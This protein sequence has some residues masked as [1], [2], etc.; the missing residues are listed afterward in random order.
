MNRNPNYHLAVQDFQSA[1]LRGKLQGV[2]AR[3]TGKSNELLSYEE[4]A[5]KLKLQGRSDKGVQMIPVDAIIGSVGRY[6]DFTRTFLPR[7]SGDQQ[8]WANVKTV[9]MNPVSEGLK[10]IE[11]YKVSDVYFV[12]DGNHRVSIA[13]QDGWKSIE[14]HVIEIQTDIPLTPDVQ[15]EELIVKAEYADFLEQTGMNKSQEPIDLKITIPGG[16]Q[17][18]LDEISARRR[19]M[20]EE[21]HKEHPPRD[22]AESWYSEIYMPFAEAVRER[23]MMRWFPDRTI[24]DLYVWMSEHRGELEKELGWTIRP[25]AAAEAVIQTRSRRATAE[26]SK[27]GSW[28]KARLLNRYSEHLFRDILVPIGRSPESWD[29]LEQAIQIAHRE[30]AN[31]LALHTVEKAQELEKP[32][33]NAL[34]DQFNK[35]CEEKAA[36]GVLAVEVGEPTQKI[37]E[38]AALADLIVMK[39]MYPPSTGIK[40]LTSQVRTLITR[41]S[42]PILAIPGR[43]SN[44][45]HALLAFD[46]SAK[47]KEALF[48]ATYLAEQWQT[49]L[50]V[51]TGLPEQELDTSAQDFARNYLEFNEVEASFI[52]QKYSPAV[53]KLTAEEINADL[54]I[55]GGY[56][57]SILKEM[58][59]GSSVNEMLRGF[60]RPVL[61]CR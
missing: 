29:A 13:R 55:M 17:K 60:L 28:R 21:Q 11:V 18:L 44:F 22:A 8:R 51:L 33:V 6:T 31:I 10:P 15:P 41:S 32:E 4:V 24:T 36:H 25:E 14:A 16:Y 40:S 45:Q 49:K 61:I 57:G 9:T 38:R 20:E 26:E 2:L 43:I 52:Q 53:L 19:Q 47:A 5:E 23:G 50:T 1:H 35:I 7:R 12:I 54:V 46:G 37:L 42:R 30:N 59:V 48:V 58:T 3:I 56:S 27:T 39:I 34:Q